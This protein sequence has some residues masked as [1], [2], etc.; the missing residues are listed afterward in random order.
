MLCWP[1]RQRHIATISMSQIFVMY[2]PSSV[3]YISSQLLSQSF[4]SC[5]MSDLEWQVRAFGCQLENESVILHLSNRIFTVIWVRL[6]FESIDSSVR[7]LDNS[8]SS[9]AHWLQSLPGFFDDPCV[10]T[11]CNVRCLSAFPNFPT[12]FLWAFHGFPSSLPLSAFLSFTCSVLCASIS[13]LFL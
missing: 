7:L 3:D 6:E 1:T 13:W 2:S 11:V 8:C 12:V 9:S 5:W 10:S 4:S